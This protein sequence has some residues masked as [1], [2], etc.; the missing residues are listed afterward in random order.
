MYDLIVVGGGASG[1]FAAITSKENASHQKILILEKTN[2]LLSKVALSG[3]GRCNLTHACFDPFTLAQYYPRGKQE[4]IGPF[5]TFQPKDTLSWF[6]QR[7]VPLQTENDGR[8]FPLSNTSETIVMTLISEAKKTGIEILLNQDIENITRKENYFSLSRKDKP[9]FT[10]HLLLATGSSPE[11]YR[12]AKSL[13]HSIQQ[14]IPSLFAFHIPSFPFLDCSGISIDVEASIANTSFSQRGSLLITHFGCSGPAI[15]A[16]SSRSARYLYEKNYKSNLEINFLPSFSEKEIFEKLL[17]H[18]TN[19]SKKTLVTENP[20]SISKNLWEAL[21]ENV[22][23]NPKK[24]LQEYSNKDFHI[25][26]ERL[27]KSSY[28]IEGKAPQKGEFVTCGGVSLSEIDWKTMQS[29]ICKGLFFAGEILDVDGLTGGFNL[30]NA[31][32][33][34][35]IAGKSSALLS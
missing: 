16:L 7:K 30:Q 24:T 3:G 15:M 5:H 33:T 34:G 22:K 12:W 25:L 13:N 9:L 29:K 27:H 28:A 4:L 19:S 20:F 6:E 21:I 1:L 32:T 11:G 8:I 26:C 10:K 31:W 18:K 23:I 14:P 17:W 35:Y 2:K